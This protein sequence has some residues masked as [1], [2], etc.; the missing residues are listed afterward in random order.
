MIPTSTSKQR[1]RLFLVEVAS[2]PLLYTKCNKTQRY[3]YNFKPRPHWLADI[4]NQPANQA[5]NQPSNQPT[6][7]AA[8]TTYLYTSL[9]AFLQKFRCILGLRLTSCPQ[10]SGRQIAP[11]LHS[12][13]PAPG[14]SI[15][16]RGPIGMSPE[17]GFP[18]DDEGPILRFKYDTILYESL[19][20][21]III[22]L[23]PTFYRRGELPRYY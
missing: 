12:I 19:L 7:L 11:S 9:R 14:A 3:H 6:N 15:L 1:Q 13:Q 23:Y 4:N 20:T 21:Y 10:A 17:L 8:Q 18:D 5:T 22:V 2:H 16:S